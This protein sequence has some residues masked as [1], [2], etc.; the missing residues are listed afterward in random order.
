MELAEILRMGAKGLWDNLFWV[1]LI[2]MAVLIFAERREPR[3]MWAWML[4]LYFLPVA[5]VLLYLLAGR[6]FRRK[7]MFRLKGM[8]E[9]LSGALKRQQE[10]LGGRGGG[11]LDGRGE[12]FA[13]LIR[14]NLEAAKA[15]LTVD[16][17]VDILAEGEALYADMLQEFCRAKDYI[18]IQSYIIRDDEIFRAME[19]CLARKRAEGVQ[20]RI[21][22]DAVGSRSMG[23]AAVRRLC[24]KGIEIG[25]FFPALFGRLQIRP[26]YRNHRKIVVVDGRAAYVGGF[27]I[28]REYVGRDE[29]LGDWRD[30]HLKIQ[31]SAVLPLHL[32]F[33]Q[34]WDYAMREDLLG[35]ERLLL[36][37]PEFYR[38]STLVQIVSSG[39]D[40]KWQNIRSNY[41]RL[42]QLAQDHIYVQTPYFIPDE[43][44]LEALRTAALSGVRVCVMVPGIPDHPFVHWATASYAGDILE[45]GAHCY[46]YRQGFLHAKCVTADGLVFC[47]G[48]AN[49]DIRSFR[50]NFEVNA[51]VYDREAAGKMEALFERDLGGCTE[52]TLEEY[53]RRGLGVRVKEQFCRLLSPVL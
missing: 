8:E 53:R 39:P 19:D 48:T 9:E 14:Y 38:G 1:N 28:G 35:D 23:R 3:A 45:A 40:S 22:T 31:G 13:G 37:R 42:I 36:P 29:R 20:V 24:G 26:N 21:L 6:D 49:L 15:V 25:Q 27:N 43:T 52:V 44:L 12:P 46:V 51:V 11:L 17:T 2:L 30:T 10:L 5:G 32:R 41:L 4:A 47:C 18:H 50:L 34:D 16:N 7:K 33:I